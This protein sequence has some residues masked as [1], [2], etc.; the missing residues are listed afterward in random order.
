MK[1]GDRIK[2]R[3]PTRYSNVTAI[4]V[5][6]EILPNGYVTVGFQGW[7]DFYVRPHEILEVIEA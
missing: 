7:K 4:R 1:V 6:R 3:S 5:I 2:F